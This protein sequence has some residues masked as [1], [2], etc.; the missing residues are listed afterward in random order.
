MLNAL[1][2]QMRGTQV[3]AAR[4]DLQRWEKKL[5]MAEARGSMDYATMRMELESWFFGE[6][7]EVTEMVEHL[8]RWEVEPTPDPPEQGCFSLPCAVQS[9]SWAVKMFGALRGL[10]STRARRA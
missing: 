4:E 1:C 2:A 8:R 5:R 3:D 7:A 10:N 9:V 6:D